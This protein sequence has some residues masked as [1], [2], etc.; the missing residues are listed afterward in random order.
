MKSQVIKD[1]KEQ[2]KSWGT[3]IRQ[4]KNSRK[5]D[6]RGDVPLWSIESKIYHLKYE[7][8]HHHIA[9]CELR[10]RTREQIEIPAEDHRPDQ[11]FIDSIKQTILK[12]LEDESA[13]RPV[14]QG[15][16]EIKQCCPSGTRIS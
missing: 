13:L 16:E 3:E 7:F 11:R 15:P 14:S 8:R 2:L 9:Y 12:K 5:M 6:K 1:L 10:G 4:L